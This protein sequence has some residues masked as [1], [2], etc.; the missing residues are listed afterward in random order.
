MEAEMMM[1]TSL[2][3]KHRVACD[4]DGVVTNYTQMYLN[5]VRIGAGRDIPQDWKPPSWDLDECLG[6]TS[7]EKD[8]AY[9]LMNGPGMAGLI[10]PYP[11]A[12]A[13]IKALMDVADV[14]FVTSSLKS[15][16]TWDYDRRKMIVKVFGEEAAEGLTFTDHKYTFGADM[17][18]DDKPDHCEEWM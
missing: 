18:I 5:A 11:D 6:L 15:S 16:P 7:D 10:N 4:V 13:G 17:F 12:V 14:F 9:R 2:F 1:T 8:K 3:E